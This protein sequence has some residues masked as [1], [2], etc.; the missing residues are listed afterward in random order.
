MRG[1]PIKFF[2]VFG[3]TTKCNFKAFCTITP[4]SISKSNTTSPINC[5]LY[6]SVPFLHSD[7]VETVCGNRTFFA[8]VAILI[9]CCQKVCAR[10]DRCFSNRGS[11]VS[12]STLW[13]LCGMLA[14]SRGTTWNIFIPFVSTLSR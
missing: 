10:L 7:R 11:E 13:Y 3:P 8:D 9:L 14:L 4:L 6:I 12:E 2:F 1:Q 5:V